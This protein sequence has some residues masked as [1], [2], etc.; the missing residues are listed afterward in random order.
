MSRKRNSSLRH[1]LGKHH[2]VGLPGF[3]KPKECGGTVWS[4]KSNDT[5]GWCSKCKATVSFAGGEI[6]QSEGIQ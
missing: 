5:H 2:R 3:P 1:R 4:N 6:V